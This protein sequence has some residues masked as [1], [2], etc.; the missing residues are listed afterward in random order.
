MSRAALRY[1]HLDVFTDRPFEGNQLAVFPDGRGLEEPEMQAIAREMAFSETTFILPREDARTDVRMRIFTPG[2]E[3]P[4]AGHPTIGSTFALAAEG[5]IDARQ[6]RFV[7]GLGVGPVPVDLTWRNDALHFASMTQ[8]PPVFGT[9]LA[10]VSGIAE[11][12]GVDL[13]DVTATGLPV[14]TVSCGVPFLLV[15]MTTRQAVDSAELN[16][17]ALRRH[18]RKLGLDDLPVFFFTTERADDDATAYSRMFGPD[19]GAHE[20]PATGGASGPLGC[21][22]LTHGVVDPARA[23]NMVSLQG[24]K[25]KRPSRIHI[26]VGAEGG[27]INRVQVGG[28]AVVVAEGTLRL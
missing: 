25:M 8:L 21:Y 2:S 3:L 7:F 10:D 23:D 9:P 11:G 6:P 13:A 16:V 15:P 12:L 27:V 24:V 20:D 4:M 5:T 26:S 19:G 1:L 18:Y 14:Q 28:R 22:L 17:R